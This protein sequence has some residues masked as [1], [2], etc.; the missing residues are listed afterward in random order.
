MYQIFLLYFDRTNKSITGSRPINQILQIAFIHIGHSGTEGEKKHSCPR[1]ESIHPVSSANELMLFISL[2]VRHFSNYV[3]L[4][5][6]WHRIPNILFDH[7]P[8]CSYKT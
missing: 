4:S 5:L 6:A 8:L 2:S 7:V 1:L 3:F